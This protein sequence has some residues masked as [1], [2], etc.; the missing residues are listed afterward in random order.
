MHGKWKY[1]QKIS[2]YHFETIKYNIIKCVK[3]VYYSFKLY[4]TFLIETIRFVF[5]RSCEL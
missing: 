1:A 3:N 4:Y 2:N 5:E